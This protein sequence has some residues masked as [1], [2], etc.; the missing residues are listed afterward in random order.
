MHAVIASGTGRYRDPW[1]PFE[2]TTPLVAEILTMSGFSVAIDDDVDRAM[3]KLHGVDLLVVNAG[4]PWRSTPEGAAAPARS[5][6]GLRCA[7]ERGIGIVALHCAV[8]SL[9]DYPDWFP[10]IGGMWVPGLSF[11]PPADTAH[12]TGGTLPGGSVIADFE[13]NDERYCRIQRLGASTE[14]AHHSHN[15][16]A[17]PAAWVREHGPSRVAVDLLGHD[18]RSYDSAG[19]RGLLSTL[20]LWVAGSRAT[21]ADPDEA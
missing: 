4:D 10:A 19:H 3:T 20:A 15:G 13:V 11:H 14:V 7:L 17:E 6:N 8:S 16:R 12:I 21:D 1:H 18:E 2:R 5:V 9:R